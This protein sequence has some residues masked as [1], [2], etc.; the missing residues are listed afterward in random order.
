MENLSDELHYLTASEALTL[1]KEKK[2]WSRSS[3]MRSLDEILI[4]GQTYPTYFRKTLK[5]SN[6]K[7]EQ[8]SIF[9]C[10]IFKIFRK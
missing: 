3:K 4:L 1:F 10:I 9:H 6:R 7:S 8:N 5:I 2:L